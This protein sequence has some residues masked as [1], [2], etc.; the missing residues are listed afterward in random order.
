MHNLPFNFV[1]YEG[2]RA[3]FQ[4]LHSDIQMISRIIVNVDV[5]K[6]Y[7]IQKKKMKSTL[8]TCPSRVSLTSNLRTSMNT[9]EY[10]AMM[11]HFIDKIGF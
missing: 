4:C 3:I 1:E 5:L 9:N 8:E 7:G 2:A 6:L 10:L 11:V